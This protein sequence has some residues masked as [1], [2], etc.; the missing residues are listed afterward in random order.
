[1]THTIDFAHTPT[2]RANRERKA[3]VLATVRLELGI[4]PTDLD[5]GGGRRRDAWRAAGLTRNPSEDTWH[6]TATILNELTPPAPTTTHTD[7]PARA[8][9]ECLYGCPGSARLYM[10]GWLCPEHAPPPPP[11]PPAGTTAAEI[12]AARG[13]GGESPS[14]TV[15]DD[16]AVAS[17]K[18]RSSPR[19]F[20][21]ARAAEDARRARGR[22]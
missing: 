16:R 6:V 9:G 22:R 17:G 3:N 5:I 18:R 2:A 15:L 8:R 4:T 11:T 1:M 13:L 12:R 14:W 21:A 10:R 19:T 20:R 7:L